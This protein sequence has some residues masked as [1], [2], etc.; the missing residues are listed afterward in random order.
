MKKKK[1]RE[2][3]EFINVI[4]NTTRRSSLKN[5]WNDLKLWQYIQAAYAKPSSKNNDKYFICLFILD[6]K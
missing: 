1:L 5:G 4:L 6:N 3:S 2:I